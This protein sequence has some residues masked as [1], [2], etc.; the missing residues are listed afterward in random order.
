MIIAG[1]ATIATG[2]GSLLLYAA[3]ADIG[4]AS[5]DI[6]IQSKKDE[7]YFK[8]KE[9]KE[10]LESWE[11]IYTI[12]GVVTFSPVAVKAVVTYGPKIVSSGA[13]LL[14]VTGKTI[15]NPEL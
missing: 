10:F 13:D 1:V 15:T 4:L 2:T 3:I 8:S 7:A 14:Q 6:I 5:S 12:G 11:K 9:G